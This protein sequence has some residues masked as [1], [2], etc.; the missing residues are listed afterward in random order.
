MVLHTSLIFR[1]AFFFFNRL[2]LHCQYSLSVFFFFS[3][4]VL[5]LHKTENNSINNE[6]EDAGKS[7]VF[8]SS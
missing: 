3:L 8:R 5:L 1:V 4:L 2:Y 7:S 6:K